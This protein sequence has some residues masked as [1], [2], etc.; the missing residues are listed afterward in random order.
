MAG[1][2]KEAS[3]V[4]DNSK[5]NDVTSSSPTILGNDFEEKTYRPTLKKNLIVIFMAIGYIFVNMVGAV[6]FKAIE[7]TPSK[8][9]P[10]RLLDVKRDFLQ[11]F[12][13]LTEQHLEEFLIVCKFLIYRVEMS[14]LGRDNI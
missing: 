9:T 11:N 5:D 7:K 6:V 8:G 2:S 10:H 12:S 14:L 1:S 3:T 4:D 13:C